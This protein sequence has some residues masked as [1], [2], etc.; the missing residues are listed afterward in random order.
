MQSTSKDLEGKRINMDNVVYLDERRKNTTDKSKL[1][2]LRELLDEIDNHIQ[3]ANEQI[4]IM[5]DN[6]E[7]VQ[8]MY[9]DILEEIVEKEGISNI[10]LDYLVYVKN[11]TFSVSAE[12]GV[13]VEWIRPD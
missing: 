10:P 8:T 4:G 9:E 12:G 6:F 7:A 2:E 3:M 5:V 1:N 13:K 11:I